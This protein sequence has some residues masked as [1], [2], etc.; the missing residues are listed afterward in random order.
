M[1][2]ETEFLLLGW[3]LVAAITINALFSERKRPEDRQP[4][5]FWRAME[6]AGLWAAALVGLGAI[7]FS[8]RD[9]GEQVTAMREQLQTMGGQLNEMQEEGRPWVGPVGASLARKDDVE[10]PLKISFSYRNFG[11]QPATRVLLR[12]AAKFPLLQ[13]GFDIAA[14]PFWKDKKQFDPDGLCNA[15]TPLRNDTLVTLYPSDNPLTTGVGVTKDT[16]VRNYNN[17]VI[18]I[19]SVVNEVVNKRALYVF[20]GCLSYT[21]E[22]KPQGA[23]FC[24]MLDPRTNSSSD[25]SAWTINYCPYGNGSD[26]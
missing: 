3:G 17:A 6:V 19:S 13:S 12:S 16:P 26:P 11:R 20:Y 9:S 10:E 25:I 18:P 1:R 21:G 7:Y 2:L 14:L 24:M 23:P 15:E 22:G 4:V 8:T 5:E